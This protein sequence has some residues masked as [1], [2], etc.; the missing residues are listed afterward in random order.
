MS[1]LGIDVGTTGCKVVAFNPEG[2]ILGL[3]YQEYPLQFPGKPGWVE[4]DSDEVWQKVK[5]CIQTV[6]AKTKSDP[7]K[8]MAV[9]SQGE[10]VTPLDEKGKALYPSI[11]SFDSRTAEFIPWWLKRISA[12]Q[13]FQETGMTPEPLFTLNKIL[14]FKKYQQKLYRQT[15]KF[16]CFED[17]VNYRLTGIPAIDYSLAARMM[18]FDINNSRW[19]EKMLNLAGIDEDKLALLYPSGK[20]IGTILPSIAR[21]LG[22]SKNTLVVSGGHDQPCGALGAGVIQPGITMDA[23]GTVECITPVFQKPV[24]NRTMLANRFCC[25]PHVVPNQYVTVAYTFTGGSLLRWYRDQFGEKESEIAINTGEDVYDMLVNQIPENP[26]S[27]FILPHF[28]TTGTPY[29]DSNS[30]GAILGLTLS[31]T[32]PEVTR[33]ILEGISY[34]IR[35]NIE[36]LAQSG[37]PVREI[38]AIGGGAKSATWLQLKADLYGRKIRALNVSEAASLGAAMLAG[39]AIGEYKSLPEAVTQTVKINRTFSPKPKNKKIYNQN[40]KIYQQIYPLLK[41]INHQIAAHDRK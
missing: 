29:F 37:I 6:A 9:S 40:F 8:A 12:Y 19:S 26:S 17:L 15:W 16:L 30:R 38:R 41:D 14:W 10:G 34:E 11:V 31:T 7:I 4:L 22:L 39:W 18:C 28:T 27:L 2:K 36:L 3:A 1:L 21:D 23:I 5:W 35:L 24:I 25:Y 32:K 20:I 13:L 33:A